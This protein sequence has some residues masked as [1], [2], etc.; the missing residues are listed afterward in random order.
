M[1]FKDYFHQIDRA[2]KAPVTGDTVNFEI[3]SVQIV[4][5]T[6]VE[7]NQNSI[8]V[9]LDDFAWNMLDQ[10][11]LLSE[12]TAQQMAE[13]TLIFE[14]DGKQVHKKFLHQPPMEAAG[15]T[16]DF[17]RNIAK[18]NNIHSQMAT[19]GYKLKKA[20]ARLIETDQLPESE[21]AVTVLNPELKHAKVVFECHFKKTT[22]DR[23]RMFL[24]SHDC[25]CTTAANH[26]SLPVKTWS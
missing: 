23:S 20:E 5:S 13:F 26:W 22:A 4:K 2:K 7:H 16:Q 9:L 8:T 15:I 17:V 25:T 19:E 21:V 24:E 14:R 10:L 18:S 1:S 3:N 11:H 6:V 12:G